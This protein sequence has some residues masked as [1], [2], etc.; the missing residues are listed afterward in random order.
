MSDYHA[1]GQRDESQSHQLS[2]NTSNATQ[3]ESKEETST[4]AKYFQSNNRWRIIRMDVEKEGE[5]PRKTWN[6][7]KDETSQSQILTRRRP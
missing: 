2:T 5:V 6:M 3:V 7:L 1:Q 4:G